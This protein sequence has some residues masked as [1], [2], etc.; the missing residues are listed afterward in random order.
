[1]IYRFILLIVFLSSLYKISSAQTF[2]KTYTTADNIMA[3]SAVTISPDG[4]FFA[5]GTANDSAMV[6]KLDR[7]GD[8]IWTITFKPQG[9]VNPLYVTSMS[10]TSDNY[11]IGTGV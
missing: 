8:V 7:S 1:M 4:N 6:M 2:F 3:G 5:G 11:L 10:I 9:V